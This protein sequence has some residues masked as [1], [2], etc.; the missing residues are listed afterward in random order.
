[1]KIGPLFIMHVK[2][3]IQILLIYY[4]EMVQIQMKWILTAIVHFTMRVLLQ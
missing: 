2:A 1:M 3:V 4:S